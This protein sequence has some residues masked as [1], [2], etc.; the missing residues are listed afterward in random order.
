MQLLI[1]SN[2]YTLNYDPMTEKIFSTDSV[3]HLNGSFNYLIP[4]DELGNRKNRVG[5]HKD[6]QFMSSI[7]L[8]RKEC[9]E[10]HFTTSILLKTGSYKERYKRVVCGY[11]DFVKSKNEFINDSS[12]ILIFGCSFSNDIDLYK[13][14]FENDRNIYFVYYK[15]DS[16]DDIVDRIATIERLSYYYS[17]SNFKNEKYINLISSEDLENYL[18][19]SLD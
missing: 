2:I 17:G 11:A 4:L 9:R 16:L 12:A 18:D 7:H 8:Y 6:D 1:N 14:L 19:I 10:K 15:N 13:L 3:F 5:E